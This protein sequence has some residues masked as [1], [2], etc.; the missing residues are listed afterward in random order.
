MTILEDKLAQTF[1]DPN[2]NKQDQEFIQTNL[3][4]LK[5]KDL[6]TYEHSMRVGLTYVE[7]SKYKNIPLKPQFFIGAILHD[8]G[9][10]DIPDEVLKKTKNFTSAD[11]EIMKAHSSIAYDILKETHEVSAHIAVRHHYSQKNSYPT[12]LPDFPEWMPNELKEKI[13]YSAKILSIIDF[14][15]AATTRNNNKYGGEKLTL[16]RIKELMIENHLD[17]KQIIDELYTA[18][19]FL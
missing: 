8:I 18:K 7:F 3:N 1:N 14:Y 5:T 6:A 19:I 9:K 10:K 2:I 12:E 15:D 4:E 17:Q 13:E 11:M 16:N